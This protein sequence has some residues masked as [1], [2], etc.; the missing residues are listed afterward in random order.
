MLCGCLLMILGFSCDP[1]VEKT[2]QYAR[3]EVPGFGFFSQQ[4]INSFLAETPHQDKSS[5][6]N[7]QLLL[8]A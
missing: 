4:V 2:F 8:T 1:F 7:R 5:T 6:P 3:M